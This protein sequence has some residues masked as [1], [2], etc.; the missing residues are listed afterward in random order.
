M[1]GVVDRKRKRGIGAVRKK[2][3]KDRRDN[4]EWELGKRR[5]RAIKEQKDRSGWVS[6]ETRREK[7]TKHTT[8]YL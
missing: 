1:E 6:K 5:E 2:E 8:R 3:K 7:N 4:G